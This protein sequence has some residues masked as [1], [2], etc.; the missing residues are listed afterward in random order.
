MSASVSEDYSSEAFESCRV[1]QNR[2]FKPTVIGGVSFRSKQTGF[3]IVEMLVSMTTVALLFVMLFPAMKQAADQ[4]KATMCANNLR[5][6]GIGFHLFAVDHDGT[7]PPYGH[8]RTVADRH[9]PPLWSQTIMPYM[10]QSNP[11]PYV[12]HFGYNGPDTS[13]TYLPCPA[14]ERAR[15]EDIGL[16]R[17]VT[18]GGVERTPLNYGV[19]YFSIFGY[20]GPP[21]IWRNCDVG[22]FNG[23]AKIDKID[24]GVYIAGD[25]KSD[26]GTYRCQFGTCSEIYNPINTGSWELRIDVDADSVPDSDS[27][28]ILG[29]TPFNGFNPVHRNAGN[30][31][32]ADGTVEIYWLRH[33]SMNEGGIWGAGLLTGESNSKYK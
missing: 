8:A 24:P 14:T 20:L 6:L 32:F 27:W 25:A 26:C 13:L 33:W 28:V 3:T 30:L 4:S 19:S 2:S 21:D 17:R 15:P 11:D 12:W 5:A 7:L 16:G 18:P 9:I 31:L 10:G 29:C 23:S 1:K 22:C